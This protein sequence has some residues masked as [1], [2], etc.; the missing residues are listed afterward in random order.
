MRI[1]NKYFRK[2]QR[3]ITIKEFLD[4]K[5]HL[6]R[7]LIV[8]RSTL[9]ETIDNAKFEKATVMKRMLD[10]IITL[11][12][13]KE[14]QLVEFKLL[15]QRINLRKHK[16]GKS[17]FHYIYTLSNTNQLIKMFEIALS[18]NEKNSYKAHYLREKI[19]DLK[20]SKQELETSLSE[21]NRTK[22]WVYIDPELKF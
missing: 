11:I 6:E 3:K 9:I 4:I 7:D 2:N 18:S 1:F 5:E 13:A 8:H 14:Q 22:I 15:Q 19:R 21:F 17:N 20:I 12:T 16:D 10:S